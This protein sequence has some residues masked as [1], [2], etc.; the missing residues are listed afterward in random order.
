ML[1]TRNV[2]HK[3]NNN[4]WSPAATLAALLDGIISKK[5]NKNY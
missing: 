1:L 2:K 3:S 5:Y 4:H